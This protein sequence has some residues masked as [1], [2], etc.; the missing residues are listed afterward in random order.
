MSGQSP[1][2]VTPR[3]CVPS[4]RNSRRRA[5]ELPICPTLSSRPSS[6]SPGPGATRC[7]GPR[8][9]ESLEP[10]AD[11]ADPRLRPGRVRQD[12]AAGGVA[13][14]AEPQRSVAWLSLDESDRQ[15]ASFWTYVVTALHRSCPASAPARCRCCRPAQ[16]PIEAVLTTVLNELGALPNDLVPGAR[17]LP[18]RRR[19]GHPGRHGVPARAPAAAAAP[20]DQ[21]PGRSGP[22][23]GPPARARRAGRGPRRR[24]ALHP[25]TR[26]RPTSTTSIGLDLAATRHRRPRGAHGGL[27][28]RAA[29]GRAVDAGPRTTSA[30]SSPGFAGDDRYVVDYLVEEVLAGNPTTYATSC[31]RPAILDRLSGP[32]CDAVTGRPGG[33]AMLES[34]DRANLFV[35]PLDDNRR[36]YRYHHLFADVL[37][38]HLLDEQPRRDRRPAPPGQPLVR[39]QRRSRRRRYGT[40]WPPATSTA[41]R[42]W[43]SAPSR[44]CSGAG[45]R[46]RS[47]AGCD[48][49]PDEVVRARP[50][51]AVGLRRCADVGGR[52]RRRRAA[53]AGRRERLTWQSRPARRSPGLVADEARARPAAGHR[54]RCTG[55]GW[56]WSAATC[57][58]TVGTPERAI[59]RA[60]D[61]DHVTRAGGSALSGLASGAAGD[62]DGRAPRPT[63]ACV[64]GLQPGRAH[65]RR[66]R[67]L[68]HAGGPA[69]HAGPAER[70]PAHLR[71]RAAA[72][73]RRHRDGAARHRRHVRRDEPDR[74]R[75]RR[76]GRPPSRTCG[77][78]R[79]WA[80]TPGCR[81]TRTAGGSR[82][83]GSGSTEG[84]L[85]GALGLLDEAQR[86]YAGD[87]SPN[88]RPVPAR[89]GPHAGRRTATSTR[90]STGRREHR[91]V[92][93]RRAVLPARVRARHAGP[94]APRPAPDAS[95]RPRA[96][97]RRRLLERLLAAAEEGERT[98]SVIEI[99]VLQALAQHA[100]GD[101]DG[102][103]RPLER[104]LTLAEPEG[105]VRVFAGEGPPMAA[106]LRRVAEQRTGLELRPPAPGACGATPAPAPRAPRRAA[107]R[108]SR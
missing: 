13:G 95:A 54:S 20:G 66:A 73:P 5:E 1:E 57:P 46:R 78:P 76:P 14:A 37:R 43:S 38:T 86:V 65:R 26:C 93:R 75:A 98:G 19:T 4:R 44:R 104:A 99:L 45:R 36:W 35:V 62:L 83:P 16:P 85:A 71:A 28:R 29:A 3:A 7:R 96:A 25:A 77:A 64:D 32:L 74:L 80:S 8:L 41:P 55:P 30:A 34:L 31:C 9:S 22:A 56:R 100:R 53:T 59:A 18:P 97:T 42:S 106:L 94:G 61:D 102:R 63:R 90:P 17:R 47:A 27:D 101:V 2:P 88:V 105:Y 33:K 15:P 10:G 39:A 107:D 51:L 49:L 81:R 79:S 23:A 91:P 69:D 6:S 89:A 12:D 87:F 70:R 92:R 48:A 103:A 82:W 72:W 58:G 40:P 24:P 21:H 108:S 67:M 84:D 11:A 52:V 68:D 50:V 60:A